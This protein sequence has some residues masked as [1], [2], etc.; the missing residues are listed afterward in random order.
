MEDLKLHL[1]SKFDDKMS[2]CNCG[3]YWEID[4]IG[5]LAS[6]VFTSYEDEEF[7]KCWSLENLQPL[8]CTVNRNKHDF[9]DEKW[10]NKGLF[11]QFNM[12]K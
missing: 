7:K 10:N 3:S 9:I 1:E 6:F 11:E 4:H 12:A 8:E 2:W 5:P